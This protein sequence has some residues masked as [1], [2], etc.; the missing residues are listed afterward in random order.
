[1]KKR[2]IGEGIRTI[3]E[4]MHYTKKQNIEAYHGTPSLTPNSKFVE[5]REMHQGKLQWPKKTEITEKIL[6]L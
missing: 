3:E 1:M 5:T 4:A 2:F 6:C